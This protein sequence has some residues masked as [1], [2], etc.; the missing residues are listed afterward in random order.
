MPNYEELYYIAKNKCDQAILNRDAIR[1]NTATLQSTK[2]SLA[3]ELEEKRSALGSLRQKVEIL[4]DAENRCNSIINDEVSGMKR[5][6]QEVSNEY[7]K[8]ISSD[9]GVADIQLVYSTDIQNTQNDL[10]VVLTDLSQK[11]KALEDEVNT[12]QQA[13]DNCNNEFNS[14]THRL[15]NVGSESEA[16]RQVNTYY[17]QMQLYKTK[18]LNGE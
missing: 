3:R 7:K 13:Y 17:A 12:A 14:V 1:R 18:W 2:C 16:Q 10:D 9:K 6:I 4:K 11:R 5:D 8:I 15:N